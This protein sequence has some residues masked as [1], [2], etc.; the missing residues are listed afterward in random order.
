MLEDM[1][2]QIMVFL[3]LFS[4]SIWRYSVNNQRKSFYLYLEILMIEELIDRNILILYMVMLLRSGV[5]STS[6]KCSRILYQ[7]ISLNLSLL[8]SLIKFIKKN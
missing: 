8:W 4:R 1:E 7:L 6:Q 3:K 5:R 2:H